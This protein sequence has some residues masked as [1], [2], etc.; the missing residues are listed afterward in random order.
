MPIRYTVLRSVTTLK[1]LSERSLASTRL[2]FTLPVIR[3]SLEREVRLLLGITASSLTTPRTLSTPRTTA[4]ICSRSLAVGASPVSSTWRL[5]LVTF[6]WA[7]SPTKSLMRLAERNSMPS[8]SSWVPEVRRSVATRAPPTTT[9]PTTRGAQALRAATSAPAAR[10]ASVSRFKPD[11]V[12]SESPVHQVVAHPRRRRCSAAPAG[13][14]PGYAPAARAARQYGH[15][16]RAAPR[17]C[18][19]RPCR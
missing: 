8:S 14:P 13:A 11:V 9:P 5:K 15:R 4:S 19:R 10:V 2:A 17:P 7:L 18:A 3:V 12:M 1:A 16:F 6:T